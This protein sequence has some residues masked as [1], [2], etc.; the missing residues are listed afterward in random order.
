[1]KAIYVCN[2]AKCGAETTRPIWWK[3]HAYCSRAC[4]GL[5][6]DMRPEYDF[7]SMK[8]QRNRYAAPEKDKS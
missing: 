2:N 3:L 5:S 1:M 8:G 4:A 6:G 7:A